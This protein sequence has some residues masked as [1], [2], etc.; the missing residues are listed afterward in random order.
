MLK[1]FNRKKKDNKGFTLV[2]L[3]IV[4]AILAILVGIL[5]PQYTKY[6][7]KSRKAADVSNLENIVKAFQVANADT[8]YSIQAGSYVV[9][10]TT[11]NTTIKLTAGS[12]SVAADDGKAW[13]D[14]IKEYTGYTVDETNYTLGDLKLKSAKWKDNKIGATIV[15]GDDSSVEITYNPTS[16]KESAA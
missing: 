1:L 12:N 15:V 9:E 10:M 2:E 11:D 3:V 8:D 5:A 14:A 4:V 6:V 13:T 16:I 7:E